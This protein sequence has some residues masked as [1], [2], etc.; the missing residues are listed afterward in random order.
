[1]LKERSRVMFVV[2]LK[3]MVSFLNSA[4]CTSTQ[5]RNRSAYANP[6]RMLAPGTTRVRS[7]MEASSSNREGIKKLRYP[8]NTLIGPSDHS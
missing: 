4:A 7:R 6:M 8:G 2:L 5:A 1:M 3:L